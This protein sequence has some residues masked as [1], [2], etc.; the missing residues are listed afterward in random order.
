MINSKKKDTKKTIKLY[1]VI[2][3]VFLGN[4]RHLLTKQPQLTSIKFHKI[5][6]VK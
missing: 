4:I 2:L 5:C 6:L 3:A 1:E